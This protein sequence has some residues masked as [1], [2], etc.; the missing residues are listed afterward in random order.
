MSSKFLME[1]TECQQLDPNS[2]ELMRY[3]SKKELVK[4]EV[5]PFFFTYSKQILALY[6]MSVFN[7]TTKVLWKLMEIAEWNT[8]KV[9]MNPERRKEIMQICSIS[10][11][12]FDRAIKELA[13]VGIIKREGTTYTIDGMMFWKGDRAGREKIIKE[14]KLKVSFSPVFNDDSTVKRKSKRKKSTE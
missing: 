12:S 4:V 7:A 14:A 13:D 2:G 8:G 11:A 10:R 6:G 3:T 5:E 9:F 1:E